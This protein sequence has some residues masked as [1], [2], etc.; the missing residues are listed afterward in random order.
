MSSPPDRMAFAE[1]R[2]A[3]IE[4]LQHTLAEM[5]R[6]LTTYRETL[7][8]KLGVLQNN[9][10][11]TMPAPRR[12]SKPLPVPARR[13]NKETQTMP[14]VRPENKPALARPESKPAAARPESRPQLAR[15]ESNPVA[16]RPEGNPQPVAAMPAAATSGEDEPG[17]EK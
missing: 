13:D 12:D 14:A 15:P 3:K 2:L 16:P 5:Q 11:A 6:E 9:A 4:S 8:R 10:V 17:S 7:T 1:E